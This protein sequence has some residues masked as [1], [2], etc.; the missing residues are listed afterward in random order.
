M[1]SKMLPYD[2]PTCPKTNSEVSAQAREANKGKVD[3]QGGEAAKGQTRSRM[4]RK[5]GD[6]PHTAELPQNGRRVAPGG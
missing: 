3:E 1:K 6:P 2:P 5:Q 4:S